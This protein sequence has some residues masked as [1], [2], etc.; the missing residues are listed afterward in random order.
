M[1]IPV[2]L[3]GFLDKD[4]KLKSWPSHKNKTKQLLALE[5]LASKFELGRE[6]SEKEINEILNRHHT[7]G[8]PA[9]LR[10]ELFM[11]RFFDRTPDGSRYW[12]Q[13]KG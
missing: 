3:K 13:S 1:D 9:L 6:Y 7:F 10:R 11:K 8:D 4:S 2:E 5:Y 12:L